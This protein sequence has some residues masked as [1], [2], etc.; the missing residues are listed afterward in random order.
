MIMDRI[1]SPCTMGDTLGAITDFPDSDTLVAEVGKKE[2]GPC[3]RIIM[4]HAITSY[5]EKML[6]TLSSRRNE[7]FLLNKVYVTD[8]DVDRKE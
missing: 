7:V 3:S 5:R 1:M 4:L 6:F 2:G 8:D